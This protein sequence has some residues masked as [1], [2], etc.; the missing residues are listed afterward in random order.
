M[1]GRSEKAIEEEEGQEGRV[2]GRK[3]ET[4]GGKGSSPKSIN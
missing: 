1:E 4:R 3:E 2:P